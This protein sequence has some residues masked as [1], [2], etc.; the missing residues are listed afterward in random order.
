MHMCIPSIDMSS[1]PS[2]PMRCY[3]P[4]MRSEQRIIA[5]W[6]R[7][8][9]ARK[10]WTAKQWAEKAGVNPTTVSRAMADDY[11]SVTSI[12]TLDALS[13]VAGGPSP[14]EVFGERE[15]DAPSSEA[16]EVILSAILGEEDGLDLSRLAMQLG[17][18]LAVLARNPELT[19]NRDKLH[20]F[21]ISLREAAPL[22]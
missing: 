19:Q 10:G 4:Y 1:V 7:R 9:L 15:Y 12:P 17:R 18:G 16:L 14:L 5:D 3:S 13:R 11:T 22:Q 20:G 6:M 8:V 21:A 2:P